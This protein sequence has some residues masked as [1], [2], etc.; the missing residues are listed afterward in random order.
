MRPTALAASAA[1][2]LLAPGLS[3]CAEDAPV[4]YSFESMEEVEPD[5]PAPGEAMPVLLEIGDT[6]T[7][8]DGLSVGLSDVEQPD[9]DALG[10]SGGRDRVTFTVALTNDSD[11]PVQIDRIDWF[12]TGGVEGDDEAFDGDA[13]ERPGTIQPGA[14]GVLEP[15]CEMPAEEYE[16]QLLLG[17]SRPGDAELAHEAVFFSGIVE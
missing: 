13:H 17:L 12:C 3:A 1:A 10:D 16:L 8:D 5:L 14:A 2:V 7:W 6:H 4:E 11:V 15:A 9:E